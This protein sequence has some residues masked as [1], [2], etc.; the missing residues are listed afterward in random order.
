MKRGAKA[1]FLAAPVRTRA[2]F[3]RMLFAER[4]EGKLSVERGD[5]PPLAQLALGGV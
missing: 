5:A 3:M 4:A 2:L 1:S